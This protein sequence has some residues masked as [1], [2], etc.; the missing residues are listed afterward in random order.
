[1]VWRWNAE[2]LG[3]NELA[4]GIAGREVFGLRNVQARGQVNAVPCESRPDKIL[5]PCLTPV[6]VDAQSSLQVDVLIPVAEDVG[7]QKRD[8]DELNRRRGSDSDGVLR[9]DVAICDACFGCDDAVSFGA[10]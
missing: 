10:E 3:G 7:I 6:G 5:Y 1:V 2:A 4:Y 8:G 9:A